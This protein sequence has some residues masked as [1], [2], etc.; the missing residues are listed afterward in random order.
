MY[1]VSQ[2]C[3]RG[4]RSEGIVTHGEYAPARHSTSHHRGKKCPGARCHC[5]DDPGRTSL[6]SVSDQDWRIPETRANWCLACWG[7]MVSHNASHDRIVP[8]YFFSLTELP[9]QFSR[10]PRSFTDIEPH[11]SGATARAKPVGIRSQSVQPRQRGYTGYGSPRGH[12]STILWSLS[13]GWPQYSGLS[14][15]VPDLMPSNHQVFR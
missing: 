11:I 5:Q 15:S 1:P 6:Y 10:L 14:G 9:S 2:G 4:P 12:I 7:H 13:R 3:I 8:Q